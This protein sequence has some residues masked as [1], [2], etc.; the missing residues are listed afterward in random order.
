MWLFK[1]D[2]FYIASEKAADNETIKSE[3]LKDLEHQKSF[4]LSVM[5][6]LGNDRFVTNA[7]AEVVDLEKRNKLMQKQGSN[8]IRKPCY[9]DL[10]NLIIKINILY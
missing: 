3:L 6:K 7:K 8:N 10:K 1:K 9:I 2:K 5:K 4:L